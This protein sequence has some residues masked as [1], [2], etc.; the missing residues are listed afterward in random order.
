M[1]VAFGGGREK[2]GGFA[3]MKWSVA[4][5]LLALFGL[6][7][8]SGQIAPVPVLSS[9]SLDFGSQ[10]VGTTS[11]AQTVTLANPG[12]GTLA[13]RDITLQGAIDF[14]QSNNCG[15]SLAGGASCTIT[16]RFTP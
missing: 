7:S 9:N 2:V 13:I 1:V 15:A 8:T 6:S 5:F 10:K 3:V 12:S 16:V 11:T 14:T 4:V